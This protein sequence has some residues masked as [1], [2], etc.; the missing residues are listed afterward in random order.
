MTERIAP[1]IAPQEWAIYLGMPKL[2]DRLLPIGQ[3]HGVAALALHG[4][5]FG[6]T[7]EDVD[8][9]RMATTPPGDW[10]RQDD[11][12]MRIAAKI[13]ALLPPENANA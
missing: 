11:T 6:F 7:W 10:R 13:A 4:Q 8:Y 12:L 2:V 3:R 9:I 1:A 5:P